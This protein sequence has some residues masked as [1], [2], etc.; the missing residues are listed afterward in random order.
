MA[1]ATVIKPDHAAKRKHLLFTDEH[2]DLRSSMEA[3]V[4]KELWPHRNEWEETTWPSEAMERAGE[5]GY[6]GLCFPEEYGG[7]GGDYYYSLV[8]AEC[9]S[10]S[11]SG[12]TNMGFAVQTDMVLPPIHLLGTEEQKQ[13]YLV[14]GIKGEKIGCLGI[15]EP[16]AGSDVAGIRTKAIRDGDDYVINGSKT[17]ITNGARADFILLVAKTDPDARPRGDHAVPRRLRDTPG[18]EVS[19]KLEKMGMHASDT[20]ELAFD[21]VRVPADAVLGEIGKGFYHISWELQSERMVAAAGCVA[22]AERMFEK[23]LEYAKEREAFGRPIGRFQ[24]IRHKFAEMATKIEAAKQFNYV[25]AW[26]YANGEYP[27]REITEVKLFASR[28]CCEVADECVQI[29]GGY[30]YMKEYEIERAYRDVRLNRIGAGTDE[31]ML[32]VIGRSLR[33]VAPQSGS[34]GTRDARVAP[35]QHGA[36]DHGRPEPITDV[37]DRDVERAAPLPIERERELDR[38][39]VVQV[40]QRDARASVMPRRSITA[41]AAERQLRGEDRWRSRWTAPASVST[42]RAGWGPRAPR[43]L[44]DAPGWHRDRLGRYQ[45]ERRSERVQS[46]HHCEPARRRPRAGHARR[47]RAG[48]PAPPARGLSSSHRARLPGRAHENAS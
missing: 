16:G 1:T 23:T 25:V 21:D 36:G 43:S 48:C 4:K 5:L 46:R 10:Y 9:M 15:T 19:R 37:V 8:R 31:I 22:G 29:L 17:F 14:P 18:F 26:R 38:A 20:G 6:L 44:I 11:G 45:R 34:S 30:G 39:V 7:Q 3:W 2:E 32:D 28:M 24:A 35:E 33:A 13:R 47:R 42:S 12:G 27:V 41:M 40:A